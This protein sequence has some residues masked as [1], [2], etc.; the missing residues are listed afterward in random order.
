MLLL[1]AILQVHSY[2]VEY[3]F[4]KV[5]YIFHQMTLLMLKLLLYVKLKQ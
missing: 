4:V 5:L 2:F 1:S 3:Y